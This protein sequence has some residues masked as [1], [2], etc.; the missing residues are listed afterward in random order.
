MN[1]DDNKR[2][3]KPAW[4]EEQAGLSSVIFLPDLLRASVFATYTLNL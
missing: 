2:H 3:Y 1:I 4:P